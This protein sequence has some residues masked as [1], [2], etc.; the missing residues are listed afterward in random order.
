MPNKKNQAL[1][2][3]AKVCG[4]CKSLLPSEFYVEG[5]AVCKSCLPV[6]LHRPIPDEPVSDAKKRHVAK[7][8]AKQVLST[9]TRDAIDVPHTSQ[10]AEKIIEGLGGLDGYTAM[11]VQLIEKIMEESPGS[12]L[13][14][15]AMK[16]VQKLLRDS[17]I[18]RDTA[19]DVEN[20]SD[21]QLQDALEQLVLRKMNQGKLSLP[22]PDDD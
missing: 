3:D 5:S 2:D 20:V 4:A 8:A 16:S 14:L 1:L 6:T 21:E 12:R 19:P 13:A 15:E 11:Y 17:T 7:S 10:L 22:R 9:L 18:L